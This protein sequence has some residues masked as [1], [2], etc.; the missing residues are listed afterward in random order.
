MVLARYH[1]SMVNSGRC[2]SPRSRSRKT[3]AN[4]NIL[5]SPA[6]S[7]FLQ[8]NSGEVR[9]Y[10]VA[11]AVGTLKFGAG[12]VQV[13]LIARRYLQNPGFDFGKTLRIEPGPDSPGDS[14]PRGQKWPDVGVP[15]RR[16]P[17]RRFAGSFANGIFSHPGCL[18][19]T[20][21]SI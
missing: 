2:R 14:A 10:R 11:R 17:G 6:A 4:S 15:R 12:G 3:R 21:V 1:S 13:G 19:C 8:A 20:E 9:R 16:P 5:A 18:G 7:N